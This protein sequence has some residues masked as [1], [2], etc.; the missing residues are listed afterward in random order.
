MFISIFTLVASVGTL[1]AAAVQI[2]E[3]YYILDNDAKTAEVTSNPDKYSDNIVIPA[4]VEYETITYS[5]TSIGNGAFGQCASLTGVIIGNKVTNI[6][7]KVF[8]GCTNL[9]A[10]QVDDD[11]I[12]YSS[13]DGILYNKGQTRLLMCPRGWSGDCSLPESVKTIADSAFIECSK[14]TAIQFPSTL[15][16]IGK[17]A[18][19]GCTG[20]TSIDLPD[21]LRVVYVWSFYGCTK[22]AS[23]NFKHLEVIGEQTFCYCPLTSLYIPET[24]YKIWSKAFHCDKLS[25][26]YCAAVNPPT[27]TNPDAFS[28]TESKT[29]VDT[30]Y[31]PF[32]SVSLY[33]ESDWSS[34]FAHI[35]GHLFGETAITDV[36]S[37]SAKLVWNPDTTV[38]QYTV[39]LF[40]SNTLFATYVVD[41]AGH[42]VSS[43]RQM[44]GIQRMPMDTT[45]STTDYYVISLEDLTE[46]T[47]YKYTI[48]GTDANGS[49]VY[50]EEGTFHTSVADGF[51]TPTADNTRRRVRKIIRNGQVLILRNGKTY[52]VQG[53]E[54]R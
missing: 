49:L 29:Q 16:S 17:T 12:A 23:I 46:D 48:D 15:D 6:G 8:A 41:S 3:L 47:E 44:P 22:L 24:V 28:F 7:Y 54:V 35:V 36:T 4:S 2:G 21:S 53:L 26:V 31:V 14:L 9:T 37:S 27:L 1:F 30:L 43:H 11:N 34:R 38:V 45:V 19:R 52:T 10:I 32:E 50:H 51:I 20:L 5:V 40:T 33:K 18:F 39:K 42:V 25:A 13:K